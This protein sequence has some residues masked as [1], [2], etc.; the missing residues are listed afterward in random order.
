M[1]TIKP[2]LT[3]IL[4]SPFILTGGLLF[5]AICALVGTSE[6]IPVTL[7]PRR[8]KLVATYKYRPESP[9]NE[10]WRYP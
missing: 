8:S 10:L 2:W 9:E 6:R 3:L 5:V 4:L 1:K 7:L